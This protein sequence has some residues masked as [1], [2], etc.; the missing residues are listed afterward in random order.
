MEPKRSA[1]A[2]G[3]TALPIPSSIGSA[4]V[5]NRVHGGTSDAPLRGMTSSSSTESTAAQS[6]GA[7]QRN[8]WT[9][10]VKNVHN[11][12]AAESNCRKIINHLGISILIFCERVVNSKKMSKD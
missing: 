8:I 3:D 9:R 2:D 7:K 6:S 5:G 1:D 10:K 12:T 4:N 11:T